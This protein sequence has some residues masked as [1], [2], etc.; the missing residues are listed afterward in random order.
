METQSTPKLSQEALAELRAITKDE[1]ADPMTDAEIEEMGL[2]LLRLFSILSIPESKPLG[3]H[4][5]LLPQE[6]RALAF[7]QTAL[8]KGQ[9]PSV[10]AVATASGFR[11]SRT[12]MRL[13]NALVEKGVLKKEDGRIFH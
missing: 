3:A 5:S 6:L 10:R 12:G 1:I 2:R 7:I 9:S 13:L 11:S 8:K 4:S